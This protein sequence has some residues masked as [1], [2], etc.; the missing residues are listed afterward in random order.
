VQVPGRALGFAMTPPTTG[1]FG[2]VHRVRAT[3]VSISPRSLQLRAQAGGDENVV[4]KY[5]QI[6][7]DMDSEPVPARKGGNLFS[8]MLESAKGLKTCETD[9]DCNPGGRNWP[10]RCVDVVFSKICVE[11]DDDIGGGRGIME[12][13]LEAIPVRVEDGYYGNGASN[14]P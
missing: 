4:D 9:Y 7:A 1:R 14:L 12:Y 2:G 6:L 8:R 5:R 10:L 3:P 13:A 11:S